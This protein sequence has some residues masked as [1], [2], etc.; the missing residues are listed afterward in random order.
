MR[1]N[2]IDS[3]ENID[4]FFERIEELTQEV[5]N[6]EKE[7]KE[8]EKIK[9]Q[10]EKIY[11]EADKKAKPYEDEIERLENIIAKCPHPENYIVEGA[12]I[13]G[14]L[15]SYTGDVSTPPFRVC[16]LCGYAEEGWGCGYYKLAPNNYSM[17]SIDRNTARKF[18][19]RGILSQEELSNIRFNR[20]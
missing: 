3:D 2:N 12:Y 6:F 5:N 14:S 10:I 16:S 19:K 8:I 11:E 20:K 7:F 13:S 9:K 15:C 4:S 18:V 1:K 17:K